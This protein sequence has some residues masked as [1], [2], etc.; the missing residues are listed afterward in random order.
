[1]AYGDDSRVR[2]QVH[3]Q[4]EMAQ[5]HLNNLRNDMIIPQAQTAQNRFQ[6]ASDQNWQDYDNI[7]NQYHD[8]STT[9]GL[10][11]MDKNNIRQRALSPI[12]SVYA[13]ANRDVDRQRALQGGYS[14]GYGALKSRLAREMS[15]GMSDATTNA[16]GMIAGMVNQGKQFGMQGKTGMYSATPGMANMYGQFNDSAMNRWMG[17]EQMQQNLGAQRVS[18]QMDAAKLPGKW[19]HNIGRIRDVGQIGL[20]IAGAF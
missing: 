14:P 4:G 6:S 13:G 10:S 19:E 16:E 17:T 11:Q 3:Y 2:N 1:M 5:N 8:W 20:G 9:G 18:G 7:Q 12:R 15:S